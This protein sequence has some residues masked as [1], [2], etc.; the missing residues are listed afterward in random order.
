M[1]D[2]PRI[3]RYNPFADETR[4]RPRKLSEDDVNKIE[5]LLWEGGFDARSIGWADLPAAAG[6]VVDVSGRTVRRMLHQ[7]DWRKCVACDKGWVSEERMEARKEFCR[8]AL[9]KRPN[10]EDWRDVLF[11]DEFHCYWV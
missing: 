2:H 4:G 9:R 10:K 8:E 11:T 5:K 3:Y 7:K 6:C 1:N